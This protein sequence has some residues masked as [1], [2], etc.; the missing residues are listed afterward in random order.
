M[1]IYTRQENMDLRN[2]GNVAVIGAGGVGSWIAFFEAMAGT[3][4]IHIF[5]ND[6]LEPSNLNRLP[7]RAKDLGLRKTQVVQH[8]IQE[9]I[10]GIRRDCDV[11]CYPAIDEDTIALLDKFDVVYDCTDR[12]SVQ[13]MISKYCNDHKILYYHAGYNGGHISITTN[14][15]DVWGESEGGYRVTP[16]FVAPTVVVASM[17]VYAAHRNLTDVNLSAQL[18]ELILSEG[19]EKDE[20]V[21]GHEPEPQ[22]S[23]EYAA[24]PDISRDGIVS[25]IAEGYGIDRAEALRLLEAI[26]GESPGGTANTANAATNSGLL[27]VDLGPRRPGNTNT[28]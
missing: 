27:T 25:G 15:E 9:H 6:I 11:I 3:D 4:I 1:S 19:I 21:E 26:F 22:S 20:E 14:S 28:G 5:D 23:D 24:G 17:C 12:L 16:S 18:E 7:F 13:K 8:W 10:L 2:F